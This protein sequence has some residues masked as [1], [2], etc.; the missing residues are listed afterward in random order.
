MNQQTL[1]KTSRST[2]RK[3]YRRAPRRWGHLTSLTDLRTTRSYCTGGCQNMGN[4]R[5]VHQSPHPVPSIYCRSWPRTRSSFCIRKW[6]RRPCHLCYCSCDAR[7]RLF[8][9]SFDCFLSRSGSKT[10]SPFSSHDASLANSWHWK[11]WGASLSRVLRP[12]RH[13]GRG[14][15]SRTRRPSRGSSSRSRGACGSHSHNRRMVGSRDAWFHKRL[16]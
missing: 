8:R 6:R 13:G 5:R 1:A 16:G 12:A 9:G 2:L 14:Y 10:R 15:S 3:S 11:K 4:R 7:S